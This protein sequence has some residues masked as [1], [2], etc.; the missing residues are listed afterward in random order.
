MGTKK[1]AREVDV[2]RL[3]RTWMYRF[4][5]SWGIGGKS[6]DR[7]DCLGNKCDTV[8]KPEDQR[9]KSIM[10]QRCMSQNRAVEKKKRDGI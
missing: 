5:G 9:T 2:R 3:Q 1:N 4:Q 6:K 10:G 7:G 8:S